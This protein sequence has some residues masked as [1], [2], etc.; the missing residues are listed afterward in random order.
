MTK[1]PAYIKRMEVEFVELDERVTK[2]RDFLEDDNNLVAQAKLS[3]LQT[4]LLYIQLN[5]MLTYRRVL[6]LRIAHEL[7]LHAGKENEGE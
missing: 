5:A 2:L 6:S 3:R 1:I 7:E 4:E